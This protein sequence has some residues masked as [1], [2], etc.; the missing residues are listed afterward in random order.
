MAQPLH[1]GETT[2]LTLQVLT[3]SKNTIDIKATPKLRGASFFP[4]FDWEHDHQVKI[5]HEALGQR[6]GQ[7][8][9]SL[10]LDHKLISIPCPADQ[11]LESFGTE[12]VAAIKAM[13][14]DPNIAQSS[15]RIRTMDD[16]EYV[17]ALVD[18]AM[19]LGNYAARIQHIIA[20][21]TLKPEQRREALDVMK[22]LSDQKDKGLG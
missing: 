6:F 9:I 22:C 4:T 2:Q 15:P 21:K 12:V 17:A 20:D 19:K 10:G 7:C 3:G 11:P 1:E 14:Q 18:E 5:L 16:E 13:E 8:A